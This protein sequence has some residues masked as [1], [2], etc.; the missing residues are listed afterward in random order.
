V[1]KLEAEFQKLEE[2]WNAAEDADTPYPDRCEEIRDRLDEIE[3]GRE[4]VWTAEQLAMAGAVVFIGHDGKPRIERGFVRPEDMP[5]KSKAK[6]A[7]S[8]SGEQEGAEAQAPGISA[9]LLESLTGHKSAA[10]AAALADRPD[11]ALAAVVHAFTSRVFLNSHHEDRALQLAAFPQ[12]LHRAEGSKASEHMEAVRKKWSEAIASHADLWTW[13][14]EQS[15]ETLLELLAFCAAVS[16]NAVQTKSDKG[17]D[18]LHYAGKLASAVS[19]D[20]MAWFVPN[21]ENYFSRVSKP[22]ILDALREGRNQPPAPAWEKLKKQELAALA[23]RELAG[24]GWLPE[25][26][27]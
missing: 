22:Q 8:G 12:S 18:R 17:T 11:V 24:S 1:E 21:A 25:V 14:L 16:V 19:L 13:C 9:A 10:L 4:R 7:A 27:R 26:L 23:E 15:R 5:K 6:A 20:M 3:R 2:E